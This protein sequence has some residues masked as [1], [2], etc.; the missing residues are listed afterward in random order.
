MQMRFFFLRRGEQIRWLT[1][2][3][4]DRWGETHPRFFPGVEFFRALILTWSDSVPLSKVDLGMVCNAAPSWSVENNLGR[5]LRW[6]IFRGIAAPFQASPTHRQFR[7]FDILWYYQKVGGGVKGGGGCLDAISGHD[8]WSVSLS[9]S[10]SLQRWPNSLRILARTAN[11]WIMY[12][13]QSVTQIIH[14]WTNAHRWPI[15]V[16]L[17]VDSTIMLKSFLRRA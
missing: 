8:H 6:R 12:S 16:F 15:F 7:E 11:Q 14:I 1:C 2:C 3:N 10:L 17:L 13:S 4:L 9:V 5:V